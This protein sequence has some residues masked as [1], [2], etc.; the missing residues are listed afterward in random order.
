MKKLSV[1]HLTGGLGN[2]L[3]QFSAAASTFPSK[4]ELEIGLG[5]PRGNSLGEPNISAFNLPLSIV[6][7]G[8]IGALKH[9]ARKSTGFALRSA[10]SPKGLERNR[11][12]ARAIEF[13]VS[14]VLFVSTGRL[15]RVVRGFGTGYSPIAQTKGKSYLIGYFQSYRFADTIYS[16]L[17]KLTPKAV[18]PE[19]TELIKLSVNQSILIV[20][21]RLGD[22]LQEDSFGTPGKNYYQN[23]IE[24]LWRSG[25]YD[26][27][28]VFSD[29]IPLAKIKFPTQFSRYV[30]WIEEVDASPASTL[31]AMRYG[32]G[33]VLANSTFSWWG[34][35]LSMN[36]KSEKIAPTP[37]F[38]SMDSPL[39]LIPEHW[40]TRDSDF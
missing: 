19:L 22:Y 40:E 26:S 10:V 38:K 15:N 11:F 14:V 30:H 31:Q 4:L 5:L 37:W 36:P 28:W 29:D 34:A 25:R 12:F 39:N 7:R 27:I 2:Q 18:G 1:V 3:F 16:E 6:N 8:S 24:E 33:Y 9:L 13:V 35:Y 32:N 17:M 20:H 23:A 21:Y